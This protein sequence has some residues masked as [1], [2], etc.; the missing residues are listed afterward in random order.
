MN[1]AM[2]RPARLVF[3]VALDLIRGVASQPMRAVVVP[4]SGWLRR[5]RL[6]RC[7]CSGVGSIQLCLVA[8]L[9]LAGCHSA[10]PVCPAI[11]E[12]VISL[13]VVDSTTGL[14]PSAMPLVIATSGSRVDTLAQPLPTQIGEVYLI[15]SRPGRYDLLVKTSGY[16]DWSANGLEV[17]GNTCGISQTLTVTARLQRS[18]F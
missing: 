16:R 8:A 11:G 7:R 1:T 15:G 18:L 6:M 3:D 10:A 12:F 17:S 9:G 5:R 14:P 13:M 4:S 2:P